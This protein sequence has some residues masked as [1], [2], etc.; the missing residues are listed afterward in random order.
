MYS[1][2]DNLRSQKDRIMLLTQMPPDKGIIQEL[3]SNNKVPISIIVF[4]YIT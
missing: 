4:H 2:I 3:N 1:I